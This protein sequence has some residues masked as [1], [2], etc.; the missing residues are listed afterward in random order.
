MTPFNLIYWKLNKLPE[1]KM[2][3][4]SQSLLH[5]TKKY[6]IEPLYKPISKPIKTIKD[7]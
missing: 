6:N 7:V 5:Q 4:D 3:K 2:I 1:E